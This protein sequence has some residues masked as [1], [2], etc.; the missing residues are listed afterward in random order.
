[1]VDGNRDRASAAPN[2]PLKRRQTRVVYRYVF[3]YSPRRIGR[4]DARFS[5]R[6]KSTGVVSIFRL[7]YTLNIRLSKINTTNTRSAV[8]PP[9]DVI[10][11][12]IK[13]FADS[14]SGS[15]PSPSRP[16]SYGARSSVVAGLGR[17]CRPDVHRE[18]IPVV[19]YSERP[20]IKSF[21]L[22]VYTR[23]VICTGNARRKRPRASARWQ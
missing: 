18:M 15:R 2:R 12:P 4:H 23:H 8:S 5:H 3:F 21:R 14:N 20:A 10:T 11:R 9:K 1:L 17:E 19:P 22:F 16:K 7:F 6:G 13:P